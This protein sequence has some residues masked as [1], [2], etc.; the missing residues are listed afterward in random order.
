MSAFKSQ[1]LADEWNLVQQIYASI[2]NNHQL[3]SVTISLLMP[4]F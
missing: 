3:T 2:Q 4:V 1:Q